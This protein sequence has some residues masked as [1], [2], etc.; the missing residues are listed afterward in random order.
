MTP[1]S[2]HCSFF[3]F[4]LSSLFLN[5]NQICESEWAKETKKQKTLKNSNR[6]GRLH[7]GDDG[8]QDP[9]HSDPREEGRP[10]QDPGKNSHFTLSPF[11]IA[12]LHR[13]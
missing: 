3:R 11:L 6:N 5:W 4:I 13:K 9:R 10:R 12:N 2:Q 8:P 7:E 1:T